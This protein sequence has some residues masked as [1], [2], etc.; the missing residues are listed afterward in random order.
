[1]RVPL[2]PPAINPPER[3]APGGAARV[4]ERPRKPQFDPAKMQRVFQ[5]VAYRGCGAERGVLVR[6]S[7]PVG[8]IREHLK[9]AAC[10]VYDDQLTVADVEALDTILRRAEAHCRKMPTA[11]GRAAQLPSRPHVARRSVSFP[12]VPMGR[13]A[14]TQTLSLLAALERD[15][16]AA[17]PLVVPTPP[18]P[19]PPPPEV[20]P[21]ANFRELVEQRQRAFAAGEK[22]LWLAE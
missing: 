12:E 7:L 21:P 10:R 19:A 16:E 4:F 20:K 15:Y 14:D 17:P 13:H 18:P 8:E 2:I 6:P 1:M 22:P 5:A 11:L 3:T 9:H